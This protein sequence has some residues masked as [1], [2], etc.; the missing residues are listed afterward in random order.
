MVRVAYGKPGY[1]LITVMQAVYPFI[2][3]V[4]YNVII[5]D[6]LTK[7][8]GR[9]GG[10]FMCQPQHLPAASTRCNAAAWSAGRWF[11]HLA[12]GF[13]MLASSLFGLIG[14]ASFA[15]GV[16]GDILEN[17]LPRDDL[18]N[19]SRLLFAVTIMLT[20]P[21]ECFV[22]RENYFFQHPPPLWRHILLT[23][24]I[25]ALAYLVSMTTSCFVSIVLE[26]NVRSPDRRAAGPTSC[27]R[28]AL[29]RLQNEPFFRMPNLPMLAT[30]AFGI[31][32]AVSGLI[33]VAMELAEGVRCSEG[34]EMPYCWGNS[35]RLA[36]AYG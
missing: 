17:L 20:Y 4:S 24:G 15:T 27:R 8:I 2:A 5:G 10:A 29:M 12:V 21:M 28:C 18:I 19:V 9:V 6:T 34:S 36:R 16:Q 22:V 7:I 31:V 26:I 23:T 32:V 3:M 35:T 13:A 11:V 14:F 25:V 1:I 33:V 30:A